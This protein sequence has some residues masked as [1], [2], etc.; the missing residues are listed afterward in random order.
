M[1][2]KGHARVVSRPKVEPMQCSV[3]MLLFGVDENE[4]C[5]FECVAVCADEVPSCVGDCKPPWHVLLLCRWG[6]AVCS[7]LV[8]LLY[9]TTVLVLPP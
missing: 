4:V 8:Y 1:G 7:I 6:S 2:Q 5:Q 3:A 9:S